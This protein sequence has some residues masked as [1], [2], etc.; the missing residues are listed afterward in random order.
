MRIRET[1]RDH[2]LPVACVSGYTNIVHPEPAERERR[3]GLLREIIAHARDLGSPYVISETGT[4]ATDSDWVSH[5][6]NKTEA[7]WDDC[8]AVVTGLARHAYDHGRG[9]PAR[10]LREQRRGLGRG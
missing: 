2:D 9:L 6:R 10:D 8:R 5:P 7:G 1:F 3:L 4:F